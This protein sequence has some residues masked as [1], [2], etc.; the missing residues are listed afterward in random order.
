MNSATHFKK[1]ALRSAILIALGVNGAAMTLSPGDAD[2]DQQACA[3]SNSLST[4]GGNFTMLTSKGF[5]VG[6]TNDVTTTWDGT[7]FTASSDYTGPG[8]VANVT[9]ASTTTFFG[10]TWTAHDIQVFAP[11]SYSFDTTLGGGNKESGMLN[12]TVPA[13]KLG[14]HMLFDW[15]GNNN[16]DV[17]IV[18]ATS[19]VFGSGVGTKI[20]GTPCT[21]TTKNC[22]WTG[23]GWVG[24]LSTNAPT[25]G[26]KWMLASIDGNGDNIMG[27]PMAAGGPF[28]GFNANFNFNFGTALSLTPGTVC[29]PT[30]DI[31]PDPFTFTGVAGA[32][33]STVY[34]ADAIF[35]GNSTLVSGLGSGVSSPISI[36]GGQYSK[37]GG[38]SWTSLNGTVQNGDTVKVRQTSASTEDG[39]KTDAILNIGGVTGTFSVTV[40]NKKPDPFS[41]SAPPGSHNIGDVVESANTFTVSGMD[42][43]VNTPISISDPTGPAEYSKDGGTNW[44]SVAGTVQNGDVVKVRLTVTG[45]SN[46]ATLTLGSAGNG[47]TVSGDLTVTSGGISTSGNNFTMIDGSAAP[48][49][50]TG[51]TNNVNFFWDGNFNTS[52]SDPVTPVTAHMQLSSPTPFKGYNWTAH[53]I[54]VFGPGAYT[55]NTD[56]TECPIT[57][58][59]TTGC[60]PSSTASKNYNFTVGPNQIA[61]HI[62]FDW[63]GT[64]DIDVVEVWNKNQVF[65]PSPLDLTDDGCANPQNL[66]DL[67]SSD[68]DNDGKNGGKMI[69]G[70]F[71][72]FSA[73][74]N[75]MTVNAPLSCSGIYTP[76][77]N[78]ADPS[79]APGCSISATPISAVKQG[80]WWLVAGFIAWLGGIRFRIKRRQAKS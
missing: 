74:F 57:K 5:I 61:A 79:N 20:A 33:P 78:V 28:G 59:E 62:L 80:D 3:S 1:S 51:G 4:L 8:S 24:G 77:V 44:T 42:A 48:G 66:W 58:L 76:S 65:G 21:A 54:R 72:G 52:G 69:D 67:M 22:L 63:N 16:I 70:P 39:T 25:G 38:L 37:D 23:K 40:I 6:G 53:H 7:A 71:K 49:G 68:W 34:S 17:F 43:G 45:I 35:P 9:A 55:I 12:V 29:N 60:A 64:F 26:Q 27:I 19:S 31:I 56:N 18:V 14:M 11:G 10:Y 36:S 2:A 75:I 41:F 13:G 50:V 15:N 30:A 32:A 47:T 46:I 73:N